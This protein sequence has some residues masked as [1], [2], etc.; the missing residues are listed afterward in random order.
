MGH[1]NQLEV[2]QVTEALAETG[3][4]VS[5]QQVSPL[6]LHCCMQT[7]NA[8]LMRFAG[9]RLQWMVWKSHRRTETLTIKRRRANYLYDFMTLFFFLI[10]WR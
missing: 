9:S 3:G 7:F 2:G 8:A 6:T 1:V 4:G 5:K 10:C